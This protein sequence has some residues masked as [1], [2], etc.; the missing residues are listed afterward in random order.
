MGS[1]IHIANVAFLLSYWVKDMRTLRWLTIIG[2][3]LLIPYYLI[4]VVPLY[5]AAGWSVV[6]L[7]FNLYR[8]KHHEPSRTNHA[9][10]V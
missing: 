7:T 4:Q 1:L 8:L 2:I 3:V 9:S 5:A 10:D 6:F